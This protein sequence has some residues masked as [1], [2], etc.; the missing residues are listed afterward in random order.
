[1]IGKRMGNMYWSLA[2]H[3]CARLCLRLCMA[4]LGDCVMGLCMAVLEA[5]QGCAW[6]CMA[7]LVLCTL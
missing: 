6:L 4:V 5:V 1:V 2:V 3:G 7:V